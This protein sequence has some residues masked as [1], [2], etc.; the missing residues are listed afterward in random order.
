MW[1]LIDVSATDVV[2]VQC[3]TRDWP[4]AAEMEVLREFPA[5]TERTQTGASV[6]GPAAAGTGCEGAVTMRLTDK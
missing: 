2:L 1:D 5:P 3:K 4:G 6:A